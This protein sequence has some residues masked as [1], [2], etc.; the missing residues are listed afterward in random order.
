[1]A[2]SQQLSENNDQTQTKIS[3]EGDISNKIIATHTAYSDDLEDSNSL[4]G[5]RVKKSGRRKR[6]KGKEW[7]EKELQEELEFIIGQSK[8]VR[9]LEDEL[10]NLKYKNLSKKDL[11]I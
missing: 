7:T 3:E 11:Q 2:Q 8:K 5:D 4:S 1:M 9:D 6:E 10:E